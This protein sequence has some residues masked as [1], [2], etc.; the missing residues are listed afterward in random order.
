[1]INQNQGGVPLLR[2]SGWIPAFA[3]MTK[4]KPS[5]CVLICYML[6][7]SLALYFVQ[8]QAFAQTSD[9]EG[10]R[11]RRQRMPKKNVVQ[12]IITVPT[13]I[14]K[15]P[16][17]AVGKGIKNTAIFIDE[18][19]LIPRIEILLTS[20]DELV[21]FYPT[22]SFG[23]R[24]GPGGELNFF[25]KRFPKEGYRL[26]LKASYSANRHQNHYIRYRIP[27]MFGLLSLDMRGG[28]QVNTN[29]T[30]RNNRTN[31]RH[32]EFG[33]GLKVGAAWTK[34]LRTQ[35][36]VDYTD[37][38]IGDGSDEIYHSTID[39]F[40]DPETTPGLDGAALFGVGGSIAFDTRDN[41]FYPS[42]G[43]LAEFSVTKFN[44]VDADDYGFTRYNLELSHCLTLS[45]PGR[46]FAIRLLGEVN[47]RL[48]DDKDTPFFERASL[49]GP[50]DL[51][52]YSTGRFRDK[53]LILLNV[54]Y[55]YPIWESERDRRGAM[56]AVLFMD[57]GRVFDDLM[58]DTF[59]DYKIS[60][61]GG[62]RAQTTEDFVFRA[63]IAKSK[64]EI[65][66]IFKFEPMF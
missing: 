25:N 5:M 38:A 10:L 66:L 51:R 4:S 47:T 6:V 42:K 54:E 44:Q 43:G 64:E 56:D 37:H 49:G 52:G 29:E 20:D 23:G 32:R 58:E 1:M 27:E 8:G 34:W 59:K 17:F 60:Y 63:E 31:F 19:E 35:L 65:N 3:G 61:G 50:T 53:D 26:S 12:Y 40:D 41:D 46:I 22:A 24:A 45:R 28:Y 57:A 2:R 9:E 48:S 30:D 7:A 36:L 14:G 55:R 62:I 11:L 13:M 18:I 21:A 33:G 39:I 15:F 16:F